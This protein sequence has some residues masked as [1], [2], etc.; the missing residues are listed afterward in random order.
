[1]FVRTTSCALALALLTAASPALAADAEMDAH[2]DQATRTVTLPEAIEYARAHQPAIRAALARVSAQT[3]E[4]RIPTSQWQPTVTVTAQLFAM[5]A[6]NTTATYVQPDSMDIPRIGGTAATGTGSFSPY[7]STLVGAGL[8]Q[9]AFDFGRIEAQRAAADAQVEVRQHDADGARLDVDFNVEESFF[10][11]FAAHGIVQAADEAYERARVHRDFA[12]RGVDSGLRSPIE[13]TRAEADLPRFDV[14]RVRARGG[15]QIAETVLAASMGAPDATI[16]VSGEAPGPRDMPSIAEALEL[17][18]RRDPALA[19]AV[20]QLRAA[21]RRTTA[22]GA[23]LRPDLAVTATLTARAG[24]APPSGGAPVPD[25]DGWLPRVP[26]WDVGLVL[27][28]P[29]LD[30]VIHARQDASQS[31]EQVQREAIRA[32][33]LTEVARVREAYEQVNV[34]RSA[35]VALQNAVVAARANWEQAD[36]RFRGGLGTAVEL[37]DAEAVRTDAEIQLALGVFQ[38]ARTRAAFGRAIAEGL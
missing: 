21:E 36:A 22:I 10:A 38:L 34:A 8:L 26:N 25:G 15:L 16:D 3:A 6:N 28:W 29:L 5:T 33:R 19:A 12:K 4:A 1:M 18:S 37:A 7:A 24:G 14:G 32:T 27:T 17:A 9:E 20:S 31:E 35:R 11:V 2:P 30:G 23:E 13:L